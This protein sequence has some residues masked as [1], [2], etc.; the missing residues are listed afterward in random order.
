M[1]YTPM[2]IRAMRLAYRA[3]EGQMDYSGVPY[4]YHPMHLA[5]QMD[6][7]VSCTVALLHDVVEDTDVTAEELA[8]EFP[9]EVVEAVLLL[10]HDNQTDY[11]DYVRAI[12]RNPI[13]KKVKLADVAH[14]S[15]ESRDVDTEISPERRIW[16]KNKY[17]KAK[18]ILMGEE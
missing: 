14:N 5:E 7:E 12:S 3:H 4:I 10:T 9:Q 8:R 16:W 1:I 2:T 18:R 13:A 15:D 6:D 17:A 11:F